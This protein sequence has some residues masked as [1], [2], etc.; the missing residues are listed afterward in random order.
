MSNTWAVPN[1]SEDW[2]VPGYTE[3]R[4]IGH[5]ASGKV[6]L[7]VHDESGQQVAIKYLSPPLVHDPA[8]MWA[9]RADAQMLREIG[10][11]QVVQVY[12]YVEE[13]GQGAAIIMELVNGVS[14]H[15]LIERQ[16][17]ASPE[18]A[19]TV[20]KDGLLGLAAA[21]TL[22][23]V[24]R[25]YKPEN[26]IVDPAGNTKLVDF[27][28]TV[29]WGKQAPAA[30]TPLYMAPE[31]WHGA[32]SGPA[33]DI[34]A[35]TAVLYECLTGKPP[36]SGKLLE[37]QEQHVTA[38]V[39]LEQVDAPLQGLIAR[40]MAKNPAGRP[41]SAIAFVSEL[42]ALAASVYGPGWE[43]RGRSE[44]AE[45]AA[46]VLPLLLRGTH[47]FTSARSY[48]ATWE[49]GG[50]KSRF[51][52]I[53]AVAA[54]IVV[55]VGAVA[56]AVTLKSN[57][58]NQASLSGDSTTQT[59][60]T[61]EP[62]A[63]AAVANVSP[64]VRVTSC[65]T[66][67]TFAFNA[68]VSAT[69]KGT[70]KYQWLYSSG[71]PSPVQTLTFTGPGKKVVAGETFKPTTAAT[72]W[73]KIE[74]ISPSSKVLDEASYQLLCTQGSNSQVNASASVSTPSG[75]VTCGSP[76]PALTATGSISDAKSGVVTYHWAQSDGTQSASQT[77]DFTAPG[78]LAVTPLT[79]TPAGDAGN[80]EAVLVVTSPVTTASGPATYT[81][82][83]VTPVTPSKSATPTSSPTPS[84]SATPTSSPTP[85]KSATPTSSPTPTK[86]SVPPVST[87]ASASA[88]PSVTV[89]LLPTTTSASPTR[90]LLVLPT[91]AS[92][93]PTASS[94]AT[95]SS[96]ATPSAGDTAFTNATTSITLA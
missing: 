83:C 65:T 28:V 50:R 75:S 95:G 89:S 8:F 55:A 27:G 67:S 9:F 72:G 40:G 7:A 17:P 45:R 73:G 61:N 53:A 58:S 47:P 79:F 43:R 20:L 78:T 11:P 77:L 91:P 76:A 19:L 69:G 81:L 6:V 52:T 5:G 38:A 82:S 63:Y 16:G 15:Q 36:F 21:H 35:A 93:S 96:S 10:V 92:A 32:P 26:V 59:A 14:L 49:G 85:S 1:Y 90:T 24:H 3:E 13:P 25:D 31:M 4:E 71:K 54:V 12:D 80:G 33:S 42:E 70:M 94:G 86:S 22:G 62:T 48:A 39:P 51:I 68:T 18:A 23:I 64:P 2:T 29:R 74:M 87:S 60:T 30:G 84:K 41:Q 88:S 57:S 34:Y 66:P 56:A 46:A 44:L 37:L